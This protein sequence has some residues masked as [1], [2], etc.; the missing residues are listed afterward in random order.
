MPFIEAVVVRAYWF[1]D[2]FQARAPPWQKSTTR[3][4]V[5]T[6]LPPLPR[7]PTL[8]S[9]AGAQIPGDPPLSLVAAWAVHPE[10]LGP[11]SP[12]SLRRFFGLFYRLVDIPLSPIRPSSPLSREAGVTSSES[13]LSE[14]SSADGGDE[15]VGEG[16]HGSA[17]GGELGVPPRCCCCCCCWVMVV[18]LSFF[19]GVEVY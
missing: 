1:R 12:D 2:M 13:F 4:C 7:P 5:S 3:A 8:I 14:S 17:N 6:L 15:G 19:N 18:L 16:G 9:T 10:C 11:D